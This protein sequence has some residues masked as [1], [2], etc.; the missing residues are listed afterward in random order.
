MSFIPNFIHSLDSFFIREI[1]LKIYTQIGYCP[2]TLHD[3]LKIRVKDLTQV[4]DI[5][6][7]VYFENQLTKE[8]IYTTFLKANLVDMDVDSA[9]DIEAKFEL[10][11]FEPLKYTK[12]EFIELTRNMFTYK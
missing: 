6:S 2:E 10:L 4:Q 7:N 12:K 3:Q 5:I 8:L 11:D 9:K 1:A